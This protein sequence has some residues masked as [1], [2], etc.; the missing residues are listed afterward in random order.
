MVFQI[1]FVSKLLLSELIHV[2]GA[3]KYFLWNLLNPHSVICWDL[4]R[5]WVF[6][7]F[8][9]EYMGR[10]LLLFS[11]GTGNQGG[12]TPDSNVY[13]LYNAIDIHCHEEIDAFGNKKDKADIHDQQ[14]TF[15]DKGVGTSSNKYFRAITGAVGLG[16]GQNVRDLYYF[17][18]STY[19]VHDNGDH[20]EIYIF[21]FSRG[22]AT[23]RA[24]S[25]MLAD[26]GLVPRNDLT[27]KQLEDKVDEIFDLYKR[28]KP[29]KEKYPVPKIK[30]IGVW[31][32]VSAL[33][34][35]QKANA[36]GFIMK[37][38][39]GLFYLVGHA[40]DKVKPH[41]FY[42]YEL[43]PNVEYG[44]HALAIDDERTSF[45][46][47]VWDE[48]SDDAKDCE[49]EQVWF[50][51]MHSNV[52]GG[53][54][55]AGLS[56]VAFYWMLNKLQEK[57]PLVFDKSVMTNA[58]ETA[59]A[60]GHMYDSRSGGKVFF[61]Y[62]PR[63]IAEL[64]KIKDN[65]KVRTR[66]RDGIKLH[67]SVIKRMRA[68]AQ[69]YGP[70]HLPDAFQV[71]GTHTEGSGASY[72]PGKTGQ[73]EK[74]GDWTSICETIKSL[75]SSRMWL[76][77]L[78]LDYS[79]LILAYAAWL[80]TCNPFKK[81]TTFVEPCTTG[82][83]SWNPYGAAPEGSNWFWKSLAW[84]R[85]QFADLLDYITPQ[86]FDAFIQVTVRQHWWV[87]IGLFA[88]GYLMLR[89]SSSLKSSIAAEGEKARAIVLKA[90]DDSSQT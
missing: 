83:C 90:G 65:G 4:A 76:Y 54:P 19:K 46:P 49:V 37:A 75:T 61:R 78:F 36:P 51:G 13:K 68:H 59:D 56:N 47:K 30:F 23:V 44:Y 85:D 82:I 40:M 63:E 7:A 33:G 34:T 77:S 89:K 43:T 64:C 35:P 17:L 31:D 22:A 60:S 14:I 48:N 62:E 10:K 15:Y 25:G 27:E 86:F 74:T 2:K 69:N 58:A 50:A 29:Q 80:W 3:E 67:D 8:W 73:P 5:L 41:L 21:G 45:H 55:R 9:S 87:F 20:D 88:V 84:L 6:G 66:M 28:K 1:Y 70:V 32:T 53:Y 71:V 16:F 42:N 72:Q 79:I 81:G 39:N 38:L 24:F 57:A 26:C 18:A 52:G 11:D 12:T